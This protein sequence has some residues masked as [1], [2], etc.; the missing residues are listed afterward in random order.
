MSK[1]VLMFPGQGVQT[2]GMGKD[3]YDNYSKAKEI[4]NLAGTELKNIIFNGPEEALKF[5]KYAQPAIF[6]ISVAAFESF[7]ECY[8]ISNNEFV[9]IG[10]SLGEYSALYAAGFFKFED[11]LN[12]VRAR[13]EFIQKASEDNPGMMVAIIGMEKSKVENICKQA[14]IIGVCEV[15]NFNSP[16]Q[17]VI[18]GV[19]P[20][21]DMAIKLVSSLK[22]KF[23]ILN[24]SGPFHSSLMQ[25]ASCNMKK[26]LE[27]YSFCTPSFGVYTNCDALLTKNLVDIKQKLVR[28]IMNPVKWDESIRNIISAGYDQ[29]IE[30]GPGRV[31]SGLLKKIDKSK[32]V[33]NIEDSI[34][35]QKTLGELKK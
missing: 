27:K 9:A 35:L 25:S 31:L 6:T 4:I 33:L 11:G 20:A 28:Q 19:K 7:K 24:V 21:M 10:H 26:E 12:M 32:K 15:V 22:A 16:E 17:I 23:V 3:L 2:I 8:D 30:M 13:G 14:S 29:F 34:S 5:T 18:A 1:I